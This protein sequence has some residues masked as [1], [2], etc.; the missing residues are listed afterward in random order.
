MATSNLIRLSVE[1]I[2]AANSVTAAWI[3]LYTSDK[4]NGWGRIDETVVEIEKQKYLLIG[5][6]D[7]TG[8]GSSRFQVHGLPNGMI[9]NW[10]ADTRTSV[11]SSPHKWEE[12]T[13]DEWKV[14]I[15]KI[16]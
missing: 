15:S 6:Y 9:P 16:K 14:K 8:S 12:P 10:E 5:A 13:D 3:A 7:I 1:K 2:I 11:S 4:G